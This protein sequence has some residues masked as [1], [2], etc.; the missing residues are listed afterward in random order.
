MSCLKQ[1]KITF[2]HG[3]ILNFYILYEIIKIANINGNRNSNLAVQNELFGAV[4]LTKNAHVNK[5][6]YSGYRI[7]FDRT[8]SFSF[9]GSG[10][11]QNVIVFGV[12][13]N[14]SIHIDNKGKDILILGKDP[15]QGLGEQLQKKCIPSI[16]AKII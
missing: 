10:Y 2:N 15:T 13:M 4:S 16:L 6:K 8:S 7:S 9:P 3:K 12:D 1:D 5:Y 11:G 14:S